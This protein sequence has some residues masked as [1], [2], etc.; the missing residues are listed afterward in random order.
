MIPRKLIIIFYLLIFDFG[1]LLCQDI[2]VNAPDQVVEGETF[3]ISFTVNGADIQDMDI[4]SF[5]G[6]EVVGGPNRSSSLSIVNGKRSSSTSISY[7]LMAVKPGSYTMPP[8]IFTINNKKVVTQPIKISVKKANNS[9]NPNETGNSDKNI[10]LKTN[11][12][13]GSK[14]YLGQQAYLSYDIYFQQGI[15]LG[16][17]LERPDLS[18]FY[19]RGLGTTSYNYT[20]N[21]SG[22]VYNY[23]TVE[24]GALYAQ[25]VG[26]FKI[27]KLRKSIGIEKGTQQDSD[28]G[29]FSRKI[30]EPSV[31]ES[32]EA[33]IEVLPLPEDAPDDF[34]NAVGKYRAEVFIEKTQNGHELIMVIEG[35]GDERSLKVPQL[36]SSADVEIYNGT[37]VKT[38]EDAPED[39]I[40]HT[41]YFKYP[42][43]FNKEGEVSFDCSFSYFDTDTKAYERIN[44]PTTYLVTGTV[45]KT[46]YTSTTEASSKIP[47]WLAGLIGALLA[48]TL[49][50]LLLLWYN[51]RS[52]SAD[53]GEMSTVIKERQKV[54]VHKVKY[55]QDPFTDAKTAIFKRVQTMYGIETKDLNRT[56]IF[57]HLSKLGKNE[58]AQTIDMVLELCEQAVYGGKDT[59]EDRIKLIEVMSKLS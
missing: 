35:N 54:N 42:I 45:P 49:A 33:T 26:T 7:Y 31:A 55:S 48:G 8:A 38:D 40:I 17:S 3:Q 50:I 18:A 23:V 32:D 59:Y 30:Y 11:L 25:K 12:T 10:F 46:S 24:R 2:K 52:K 1:V 34:I 4:S 39:L 27:G 43:V 44:I 19:Y 15:N 13:P 28:F 29:F 37:K 14:I 6:F 9:N 56:Y 36:K 21:Y 58:E 20:K 5:G 41:T 51:K 57:D 22:K 16:N 47:A 53:N